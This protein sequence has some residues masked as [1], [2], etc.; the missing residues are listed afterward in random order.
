MTR[1]LFSP[2]LFLRVAIGSQCIVVVGIFMIVVLI[3]NRA[4][5]EFQ[6]NTLAMFLKVI[7]L[8]KSSF[9]HNLSFDDE[10]NNGIWDELFVEL[11]LGSNFPRTYKTSD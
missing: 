7:Y 5:Y 1:A 4:K 6:N 10:S 2:R 3:N 8:R 9:L 11:F